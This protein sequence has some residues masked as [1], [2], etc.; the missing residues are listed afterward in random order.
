MHGGGKLHS[1]TPVF[2]SRTPVD[3]PLRSLDRPRR[4]GLLLMNLG[5]PDAPEELEVRRYL[6]QF[7]SD[8]R[9]LDIGPVQ[10]KFLLEVFILPRRPRESA[11]AYRSIWTERG[12]PLLFHTLDLAG[13]LRARYGD[14]VEVEIAMRYGSPE[15]ASALERFRESGVDEIV[16][17]PSFRSTLLRRGDPP[18]RKSGRERASAGTSLHS[19]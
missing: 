3:L 9:V 13:K 5:T 11:R 8:P 14:S 2:W 12:S 16:L 6:R 17:L 4:R 7:L 10:R 19:R 15:V 1:V 18:S